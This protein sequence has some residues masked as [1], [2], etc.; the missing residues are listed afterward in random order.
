MQNKLYP[1]IDPIETGFIQVSDLHKMYWEVSGNPQGIPVVHVHGGP[2]GGSVPGTRR[3]F[4]PEFYKIILF[5]QRGCGQSTPHGEMTDNTTPNLVADMEVLRQHLGVDQW[6]VFGGSWG[7]TLSLA[8]AQAHPDRVKALILRGIFLCRPCEID[9]FLNGVREVFPESHRILADH[10]PEE[11]RS[12]MLGAYYKRLMDPD[13]A[14]HMPAA[15]AWSRYEGGLSTL[16]PAPALVDQFGEEHLA[17]TLARTEAHYFSNDIF[18]PFNQ[19]LENIDSIRHIPCTIVQGRYDMV[20][21]IRTADEVVR[22][23]PEAEYIIVN[24]AGHSAFEPGIR[25][26]LVTTMERIKMNES[27]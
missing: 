18:L 2:G 15:Q 26:A 11:E 24:D 13:P 27:Q 4:D 10:I 21:P 6:Y 12:D 7:A 25:E 3:F 20:C 23:W 19:L 14:I 5:D 22:A 8:Y 16:L 17:L 1:P 9:W